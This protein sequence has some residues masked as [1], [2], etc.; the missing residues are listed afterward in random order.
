LADKH[1][2]H[3]SGRRTYEE[4][5]VAGFIRS[6]GNVGLLS[7]QTEGELAKVVQKGVQ[8]EQA[9]K[10]RQEELQRPLTTAE[11]VEMQASELQMYLTGDAK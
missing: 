10:Q 1:I 9:V 8:L 2:L 5:A 7:R 3:C 6:L 4:D 11:I